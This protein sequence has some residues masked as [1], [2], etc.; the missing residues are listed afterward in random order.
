MSLD[1]VVE[2]I[3]ELGRREVQE[4]L[5]SARQERE[6]MLSEVRTRGEEVLKKREAEAQ[7][8]ASRERIMETARAELEARK[9]ALQAQ[10]EV[11]DEVLE[12][13]RER[14][15]ALGSNEE[16]LKGLVEKNRDE[17][18]R[19]VVLCN[20]RDLPIL[21]KLVNGEVRGELD[22]IGG[23][24]IE[25]RDGSRR[26]DLTYETFL[27]GLWDDMVKEVADLLWKER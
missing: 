1:K 2:E 4:I 8:Q 11:L 14:L 18:A 20:K 3:L 9:I 25:S 21:R 23:F 17:I 27:E 13:A 24:V 6:R 15:R 5:D 7:E 10:K 26:V 22:C 12:R 16:L 19:G